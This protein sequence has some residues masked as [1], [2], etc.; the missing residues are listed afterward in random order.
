MTSSSVENFRGIGVLVTVHKSLKSSLITVVEDKIQ[1]SD[2]NLLFVQIKSISVK[3]LLVVTYWL[4]S[5]VSD[6]VSENKPRKNFLK[7]N[8]NVLNIS[9]DLDWKT[10]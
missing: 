3:L 5:D 2:M 10:C 4:S 7:E 8:Y 6:S 1:H 9:L